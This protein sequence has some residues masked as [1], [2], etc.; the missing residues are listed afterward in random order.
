MD[1]LERGSFFGERCANTVVAKHGFFVSEFVC[2]VRMDFGV[3]PG[4][5]TSGAGWTAHMN[6]G[7]C[8]LF[9]KSQ[10]HEKGEGGRRGREEGVGGDGGAWW[11]C[12][13][14]VGSRLRGND[15]KGGRLTGEE[16]GVTWVPAFAGTTNLKAREC[17]RG[18][19][20]R[21]NMVVAK[22]VFFVS[23]FV[24]IIRVDFGWGSAGPSTAGAG[25]TSVMNGRMCNLL[26]SL[27]MNG[28]GRGEG[29]GGVVMWVRAGLAGMTW[30]PAL[31]RGWLGMG[32]RGVGSR[33]A[34]ME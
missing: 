33:F 10:D 34:G 18:G 19:G 13:V 4:P 5:A 22:R 29:V 21:P 1:P 17:G 11:Y 16:V 8:N 20:R 24:W 6:G 27:R 15:E 32:V 28:G 3:N 12:R 26:P 2:I 31:R 7:L 25:W 9:Q 23:G 30:I 14:S